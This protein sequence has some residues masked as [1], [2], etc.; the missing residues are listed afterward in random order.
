M[1]CLCIYTGLLHEIRIILGGCAKN[2]TISIYE[3]WVNDRRMHRVII[4]KIKVNFALI[5]V[6][7]SLEV[8][9]SVLRVLK[10]V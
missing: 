3:S 4:R 6:E 9:L 2:V 5:V 7:Q 10:K 1:I 8:F